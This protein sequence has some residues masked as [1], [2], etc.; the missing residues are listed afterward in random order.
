MPLA[1]G[2]YFG[3]HM[4]ILLSL[5]CLLAFLADAQAQNSLVPQK[6]IVRN[7]GI[8]GGLGF[9][10]PNF[11]APPLPPTAY[12]GAAGIGTTIGTTYGSQIGTPT[13]TVAGTMTGQ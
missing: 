1:N 3:G 8:L 2:T 7:S 9:N 5:A 10:T 13:G 12:T 11:G 6:S 4:R